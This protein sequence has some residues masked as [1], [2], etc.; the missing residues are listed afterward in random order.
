MF[1]LMGQGKRFNIIANTCSTG[2]HPNIYTSIKQHTIK[3]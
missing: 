2:A 1:M 3:I